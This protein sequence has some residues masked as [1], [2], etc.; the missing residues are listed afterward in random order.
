MVAA[1]RFALG[2]LALSL[3]ACSLT[4]PPS[5]EEL[6]G[7]ASPNRALPAHWTASGAQSAAV[8]DDWVGQL[9]DP[10]LVA[11][12]REALAYNYDLRIAAARVDAALAQVR[13]ASASLYPQVNALARGGGKLGGDASNLQG[14]GIFVGWEID[15]WGR[16]RAG[17][18]AAQARAEAAELDAAFARQSIAALVAKS[19]ILAIEAGQQQALAVGFERNAGRLLE[20]TR[21]RARVGKASDYDVALA[22]ANW[23]NYRD[24]VVQLE[25]VRQQALRALEL[26]L[27]RY[28]SAALLVPA[29]LSVPAARV[30]AGLPAELLE[31]RPDVVAAERRVAAAFALTDQA[32]A[33]RLPQISLTASATSISS[34]LFVLKNH[35]NPVISAGAGLFAPLFL[36][37]QLQ[38]QV[39]VRSAE[40]S[41]AIAEYGRIS[42]KA[43]AEVEDALSAG[44]AA[45]ARAAV[46]GA[47]V[48]DRERVFKHAQT[49]LRVGSSDLRTVTQDEMGVFAA[50]SA[51]LR[52]QSEQIVQRINLH[53]ALGGSFTGKPR[54]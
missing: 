24:S 54:P 21:V 31:R 39:D 45:D 47:A 51:L 46:L 25:R 44:F 49:R 11:L 6:G 2:A 1:S 41:Q 14:I 50:R 17:S 43:L 23:Q 38:A 34:E 18:S 32:R 9:A 29:S 26:L 40:Q 27:G 30:P 8:L 7:L 12:I 20:L 28:P 5:S 16:L 4:S 36:G 53:L 10:T 13:V 15:L 19:W 22:E 3:S 42:S 52:M 37:G 33:A 48:Q 35:D